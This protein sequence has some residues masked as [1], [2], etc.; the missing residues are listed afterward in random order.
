MRRK[1]LM[2]AAVL[3]VVLAMTSST[4]APATAQSNVTYVARVT[5]QGDTLSK[6]AREFC[7]TWQEIYD[8]NRGAIGPDPNDLR[9]GTQ[10]IIPNRCAPAGGAPGGVY[11][12]GPRMGANG[13]VTGNA[14][15]VA[16]GDTLYSISLRFGVPQPELMRV[17][18]LTSSKI[19][20]GQKLIIPG[21]GQAPPS[22]PNIKDFAPGECMISPY[23][24]K[25]MYE[26][27]DGPQQGYFVTSGTWPAI[28]GA[29]TPSG[30]VWYM[31]D[32]EPDS[33][34]PP[35]WV[36]DRDTAKAGNCYW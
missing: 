29:R 25:P 14:Y 11:D 15:T 5:Q 35:S 28:K 36:L 31:I 9:P 18:G 8:L 21:L 20:G 4:A 32:T 34:N 33:G 3:L 26:Y 13:T 10:L 17:N 27:P 24:N 16:W 19:Y 23:P 7:T 6:L 2:A 12:R 1:L 22:S 30:Q